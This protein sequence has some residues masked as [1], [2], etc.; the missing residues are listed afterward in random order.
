MTA[1]TRFLA[2]GMC[3]AAVLPALAETRATV[4]ISDLQFSVNDLRPEDGLAPVGLVSGWY[5]SALTSRFSSPQVPVRDQRTYDF[6]VPD[7]VE[8]RFQA[9]GLAAHAGTNAVGAVSVASVGST[10]ALMP[11]PADYYNSQGEVLSAQLNGTLG[12]YLGA[13]SSVT[14]T[15]NGRS[16]IL[17]TTPE[18]KRFAS[19]VEYSLSSGTQRYSYNRLLWGNQQPSDLSEQLMTFTLVNNAAHGALQFID[20]SA[21]ANLYAAPVP[22]PA[23]IGMLGAG[24]ALLWRRRRAAG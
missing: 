24:L 21:Y 8:A 3:L 19:S 4:Q 14:L 9:N 10:A 22:E 5:G 13:Y 15:L 7:S 16:E 11:D 2:F 17:R 18:T 12:F 23:G 1:L 20:V 6:L